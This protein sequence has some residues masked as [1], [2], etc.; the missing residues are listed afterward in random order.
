MARRIVHVITGLTPGGAQSMLRKLL[1]ASDRSLFEP[2]VV[3]LLDRGPEAGGIE[4]LGVPVQSLGMRPG[5]SALAALPRLARRLRSRSARIVQT[6][7]Y[8]A[9]LVGGLAARLAG[10]RPIVWGIRQSNLDPRGTK[11]ST[12]WVAHAC[13]RLSR[14]VPAQIVCCSEAS[15]RTHAALGYDATRMVV[16][17][18]GFDV[19]IFRP[20]PEARESVREEL[21]VPAHAKLVGLFGRFDLQKDHATFVRAAARLRDPDVHFLLCGEDVTLENPQLAAWIAEAGIRDRC[22]LLGQRSDM[23]RLTAALDVAASSSFGEGFPNVIGEAMSCGVPCVVTEAG[24]S[25]ELV[26]ESGRIVPPEDPVS[27]S[28]ALEALLAAA[29]EARRRLGEATRRR[30]SERYGIDRIARRYEALYRELVAHS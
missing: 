18:N 21:R 27:L 25:G 15:R 2:E 13:A 14:S 28:A 7:M 9:D 1:A 17:P 24:D 29:P 5:P 30:I 26:G 6:W 23:P 20:D 11:R 12:R 16:I 4:A 10:I 19:G 3:S 8:H 22:H